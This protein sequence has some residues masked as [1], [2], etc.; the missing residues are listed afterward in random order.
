ML[1][2][3]ARLLR[4]LTMLQARQSWTGGALSERLEI[5]ARTLRRDVDRLR[6]LGYPVHSTSGVAGGYSL[7][8]GVSLPPLMLDDAEAVAVAIALHSASGMLAGIEDAAQRAHAKLE[9]VLPSRLRRRI[10]ALRGSIVRLTRTAAPDVELATVSA[11]STAC[12]DEH[13]VS[14]TYR[15]RAG[16]LSE[17][18]VEPHRL[19][20]M[21][22]RWYLVAWDP[23]R[24]AWRTFRVDRIELPLTTGAAFASR[25]APGD[26][27]VAYVTRAVT[28]APY[29]YQARVILHAPLSLVAAQIPPSAGVLAAIDDQ[30]CRF[31]TGG[32]S[33]G[34][35]AAWLGHIDFDFEIEHPPELIEHVARLAQRLARAAA[36]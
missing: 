13:E 24:A 3:S 6:S 32:N 12:S 18:Q 17:R 19:V 20:H 35:I 34:S 9:Q 4:L 36:L 10:K 21:E 23:M 15:S 28:L 7:G 30:H 22:R 5:T 1:Q 14:F 31:E 11:L 27:L 29:R 2:T 16:T 33:L 26:D 8:A 25:S